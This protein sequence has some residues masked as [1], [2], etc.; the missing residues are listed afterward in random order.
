MPS[1][2]RILNHKQ[3]PVDTRDRL[4]TPPIGVPLPQKA[5]VSP[6]QPI[7]DQGQTG[8][9]AGHAMAWMWAQT[10]KS[11]GMAS[12][13]FFSPWY[14]YFFARLL[15]GTTDEDGGVTSR[16]AIKAINKYGAAPLDL[17]DASK[18]LNTS[19]DATVQA[20]GMALTLPAYVKC[21]TL[22]DIKHSIAIENQSV[23][24]GVPVFENWYDNHHGFIGYKPKQPIGGHAIPIVGY[25]DDFTIS[26]NSKGILKCANSW[27]KGFGANG[28]FF[29]PYDYLQERWDAWT[30]DFNAI[31]DSR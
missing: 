13:I 11:R 3:D 14:I 12:D 10:L 26:G 5:E 23:F 29:L 15:D 25:D 27:G 31:P 8:S 24:F 20:Y 2:S 28:Y 22:R 30:C 7:M 19:P 17:W 21:E 18:P 6:L 4:K 9:C 1:D 16:S